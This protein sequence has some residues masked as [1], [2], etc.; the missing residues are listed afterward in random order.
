MINSE[1]NKASRQKKNA[2][3]WKLNPQILLIICKILRNQD[4]DLFASRLTD[5]TPNYIARRPNPWDRRN[6]TTLVSKVFV[7]LPTVSPH[8]ACAPRNI[9]R[10]NRKLDLDNSNMAYSSTVSKA[11]ANANSHTISPS[12]AKEHYQASFRQIISFR[13]KQLNEVSGVEN[14]PKILSLSGILETASK[15]IAG[16]RRASST[17]N[18]E[19]AGIK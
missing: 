12:K 11:L 16:A 7:C 15:I 9:V 17:V 2:S 6:A 8:N 19:Q 5:P 1:I 14:F 3:E 13:N 10:E 18:Y 4:V